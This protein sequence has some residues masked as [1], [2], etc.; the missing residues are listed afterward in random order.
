MPQDHP[1]S[2]GVYGVSGLGEEAGAG[3]SPLAR[4]LLKRVG[5]HCFSLRIIPARAGFTRSLASGQRFGRD[6]PRSRGV[7]ST[8]REAAPRV[9]GSSPLARGLPSRLNDLGHTAQD[10]PRSR[11][12]YSLSGVRRLFGTGS[13][14]LARGLHDRDGAAGRRARI[15][16]A[17]AGFTPKTKPAE[18]FRTDH[19]RSRGVYQAGIRGSRSRLGSSPLAR[20][21]PTA[22]RGSVNAWRIIPARAGFTGRH[23]CCAWNRRDHPRSRGVYQAPGEPGEGRH[24]SSPLARGLP[25]VDLESAAEKRIIPARAGFTDGGSRLGQRLADHPRSRGVYVDAIADET[26]T[27]GSSPLARGLRGVRRRNDRMRRIIPARAGFTA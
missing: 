3:S 9:R 25:K 18:A 22:D 23:G 19:P 21:L 12:V 24:G 26:I 4:G 27:M 11:G 8:Q 10:H 7:Y 5:G 13:S 6:H 15:I 17:R 16:P 1:R 14:P 2:R 20:G